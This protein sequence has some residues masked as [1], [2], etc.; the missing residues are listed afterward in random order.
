MRCS[1]GASSSKAAGE[2]STAPAPRTLSPAAEETA[3]LSQEKLQPTEEQEKE[4]NM[5]EGS[6]LRGISQLAAADL[7]RTA[8]VAACDAALASLFFH[9]QAPTGRQQ[10]QQSPRGG[11]PS[12]RG[13]EKQQQQ[14]QHYCGGLS[15]S[16]SRRA[17]A[18]DRRERQQQVAAETAAAAAAFKP[19]QRYSSSSRRLTAAAAAGQA[20]PLE[21]GKRE[22]CVEEKLLREGSCVES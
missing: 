12:R 6:F 19:A 22:G 9:T 1:G 15:R 18:Y 10:Q 21:S 16:M 20:E 13:G 5:V 7:N 17:A 14:Q 4:E 2:R 8:V 11:E 3:L